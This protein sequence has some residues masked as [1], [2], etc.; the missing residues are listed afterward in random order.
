[1]H[2]EVSLGSHRLGQ[3]PTHHTAALTVRLDGDGSTD[4]MGLKISHVVMVAARSDIVVSRGIQGRLHCGGSGRN[5]GKHDNPF[6]HGCGW[7][8]WKKPKAESNDDLD[9]IDVDEDA[10]TNL[11]KDNLFQFLSPQ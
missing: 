8:C 7:I 3:P 11:V 1:M 9:S 2:K 10:C 4:N 6:H 5:V